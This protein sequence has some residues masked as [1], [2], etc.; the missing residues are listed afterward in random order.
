MSKGHKPEHAKP[1]CWPFTAI[2]VLTAA[3]LGVVSRLRARARP[4]P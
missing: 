2:V 1:G 4:L 3:W